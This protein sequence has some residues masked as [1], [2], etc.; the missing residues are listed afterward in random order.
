MTQVDMI[1]DVTQE[2][3]TLTDP[4]N[5]YFPVLDDG[6]IALKGSMGSDEEIEQAA[7]VSY[8]K[9]TRKVSDTRNLLRFLLRH[10]HTTPFEMGELKFHLRA[11][12][13]VIR[14]WHRHRT[15]SYNEYSGRYSEMIDSME[16]TDPAK[17]RLQS[18]SNKQGSDGFLSVEN[19]SE[20]EFDGGQALSEDEGYLQSNITYQYQKRLKAGV[21]KEQAR[22]DLPVSNYTEMYAKVDLKNLFGFLR[23]RCD[24]HAQW[25]IR[26]Y[27]NV[28][29]GVVQQLFPISF[30]AWYDYHYTSSNLTRLDKI[31]LYYYIGTVA[32]IVDVEKIGAYATSI[33]M[34]KRELDEFWQKIKPAENQDFT[35]DFSKTYDMKDAE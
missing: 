21:A 25:E 17:W 24:S 22:K 13:Y 3:V 29:A 5:H 16:K 2:D 15:W 32:D 28:M 14:Q 20:L 34:G 31:L 10:H 9:G 19:S 7:R 1:R 27:A 12:I 4:L 6:F 8:G 11:P 18:G 30:E 23:L 26:Q 35:L 33:G